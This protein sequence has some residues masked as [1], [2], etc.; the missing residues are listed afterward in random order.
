MV[1][2]LQQRLLFPLLRITGIAGLLLLLYI[3]LHLLLPG[4]FPSLPALTPSQGALLAAVLSVVSLV[5]LPGYKKSS[6][7]VSLGVG[8]GF[9]ILALYPGHLPLRLH[10]GL[11]LASGTLSYS[12]ALYSSLVPVL[13]RQLFSLVLPVVLVVSVT[14][15][16]FL[17]PESTDI[18]YR[19][20]LDS[21]RRVLAQLD[22]AYKVVLGMEQ[23][24]SSYI[25][26][27]LQ[28]KDDKEEE[29]AL[30][31]ELN[32]RIQQM[33]D[34]LAR[35]KAVEEE[36]VLYRDEIA[37]LKRKIGDMEVRDKSTVAIRRVATISE[38]VRPASPVVR[39]FA[40]RLAS[41]HPGSF[42]RFSGGY[43]SP[44]P[45]GIA[46]I[47]SIHRY[48][49]AEWKYIS[50]PL[51]S[52][53]DYYSPADRTIAL[54]LSGDC[55]DFAVL[56]ASCIEA[57]GGRARI[58]HGSCSDGAHA[59]AEAYIGSV[60]AW[61]ETVSIT[62]KFYPGRSVSYLEPRSADDYWLCLDWQAGIYS[63]GEN[64]GYMYETQGRF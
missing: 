56:L 21:V 57:I 1:S 36:N 26:D 42:S 43:P 5:L 53:T 52:G 8:S 54:G 28:N 22:P 23:E 33:E 19:G 30:V 20:E 15:G 49:A 50:D 38:A 62:R 3:S 63:C 9:I 27:K 45:E 25:E 59:W 10:E 24:L 35:F 44:G 6:F 16:S 61:N 7:F 46:Q 13:N 17:L 18:T 4:Q 11:L 55:D 41:A 58:L 48:I 39:D 14:A 51:S 40:V 64:P 29:E 47:L 2:V 37:A 34:E 12:A 60:A 31:H 32:S